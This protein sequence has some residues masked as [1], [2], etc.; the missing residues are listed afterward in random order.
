MVFVEI[1]VLPQ[2]Y[3]FNLKTSVNQ[4]LYFLYSDK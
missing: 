4:D 1:N 2:R 3:A